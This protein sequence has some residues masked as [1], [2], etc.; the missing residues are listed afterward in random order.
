VCS[1]LPSA[2]CGRDR[3]PAP[4]VRFRGV[5]P[6]SVGGYRSGGGMAEETRPTLTT[7]GGPRGRKTADRTNDISVRL[8]YQ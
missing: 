2:I 3:I 4:S 5:R 8:I 6:A 1:L 7:T